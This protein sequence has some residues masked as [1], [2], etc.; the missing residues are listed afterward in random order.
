MGLIFELIDLIGTMA[1]TQTVTPHGTHPGS[2]DGFYGSNQANSIG[3]HRSYISKLSSCELRQAE[4]I[5]G[6]N[7]IWTHDLCDSGAVFHQLSYQANWELVIVWIRFLSV[8]ETRW[9]WIYENSYI[10][11]AEEKMNKWMIIAVIYANF[12]LE[13]D[14]NPWPLR[15]QCSVLPIGH[16]H[17]GVILLQLPEFISVSFSNSN[18]VIPGESKEQ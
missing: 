17:D 11:T 13:R 8:E 1:R 7:G 12:R 2:K 10:W 6:L 18:F 9:K 15:Y 5:S 4:K 3:Y 16:L 14:L